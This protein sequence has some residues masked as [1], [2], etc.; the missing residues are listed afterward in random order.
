VDTHNIALVS[1]GGS[2]FTTWATT[3]NG[4]AGID[5]AATA[6]PDNDGLD[7]LIE[8]VIGGQPNPANPNAESSGLAPTVSTDE[9]N[10]IFTFRRTDLALTQPGIGIVVEYGSDLAGWLPATDGVNG[11]AITFN[12]EIEAGV[13]EI[14][15]FIPKALADDAKMFARLNVMIP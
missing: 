9:N 2:P 12:E 15:V 10:L 13:D 3:T 11:V 14:L 5:A 8:F 7:N 1:V 6:D 4:L